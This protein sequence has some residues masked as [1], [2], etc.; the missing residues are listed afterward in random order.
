MGFG[1]VLNNN[2]GLESD[3]MNTENTIKTDS[4]DLGKALQPMTLEQLIEDTQSLSRD[5]DLIDLQSQFPFLPISPKLGSA[6]TVW[7]PSDTATE[8]RIPQRARMMQI[9][10]AGNAQILMAASSFKLADSTYSKL[11]G[12]GVIVL[13]D[14]Q[15]RYCRGMSSVWVMVSQASLVSVEFFVQL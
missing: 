7:I 2:R 15:W 4:D 8:I 9:S 14:V 3:K 1:R 12:S 5:Q 11:D 6:N 10:W 13:R